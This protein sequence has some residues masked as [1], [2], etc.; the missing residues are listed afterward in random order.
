MLLV[1]NVFVCH[2]L[3]PDA[4]RKIG[5]NTMH[6]TLKL[7]MSHLGEKKSHLTG[8]TLQ[9]F[10]S[11]YDEVRVL[12]TDGFSM[13]ACVQYFQADLRQKQ[14]KRK[15]ALL[16][17]GVAQFLFGDLLQFGPVQRAAV[18]DPRPVVKE[19]VKEVEQEPKVQ[20]D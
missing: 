17:G 1:A 13:V 14:A 4:A 20:K 2:W 11:D 15:Y 12:F 10:R 16:F 7:P 3:G 5:G 6:A 19:V 8:E 18:Y 9:N